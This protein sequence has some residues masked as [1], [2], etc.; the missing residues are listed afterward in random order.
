MQKFRAQKQ[1]KNRLSGGGMMKKT[2]SGGGSARIVQFF[3][4]TLRVSLS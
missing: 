4:C 1:I 2:L 3:C